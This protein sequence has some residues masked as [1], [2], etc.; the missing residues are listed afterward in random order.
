MSPDELQRYNRQIQLPGIGL[1]GQ[2]RLA[3]ARVLIVGVGGLGSPSSLYLAA[4]GVG[5][6]GLVDDD[7]V[8]LSN[9]QRQVLY[10]T[11]A[12]GRKKVDEAETRLR[13]LN[14]SIKIEKH[15]TAITRANARDIFS[16]YDLI[17]D[18]TDNFR[19]RYTISEACLAAGKPHVYAGIFRFE[20]QVAVFTR[21]TGCYRCL[22]PHEPGAGEIPNCSE[23]G[24][25]GALPGIIGSTQALEALK[26]I[27]GLGQP[28]L[29]IFD[30]LSLDSRTMMV[31]KR[32]DCEHCGTGA[33]TTRED[34]SESLQ[35]SRGE[36]REGAIW[37]DVRTENE[38]AQGHHAQA[39]NIPLQNLADELAQLPK[40][41]TYVVYC[42]SGQR[43]RSAQDLMLR[44]GFSDV[45][46]LRGGLVL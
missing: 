46:N 30:A 42:A 37:I 10:S 24:V 6:L 41:Q 36:T 38:F 40:T 2:E 4:A 13:A 28:R 15:S 32:A 33:N 22:F 44:Q 34:R 18:G 29:F 5:H 20:G 17:L 3:R 11:D 35:L 19:S 7:T 21:E 14:P 1:E 45:W 39:R 43:S 31:P 25:L 23:A 16:N 26:F 9:L 12:V 27:L 8:S